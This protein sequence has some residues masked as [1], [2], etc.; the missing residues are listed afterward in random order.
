MNILTLTIIT[1]INQFIFIWLR[2]LNIKYVA[3]G[4]TL[5]AMLSGAGIHLA[6]LVSVAV[7]ATSTYEIMTEGKWELWPIPLASL[8]GGLYG[9]YIG[10]KKKK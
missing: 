2:T 1:L 3:D 10:M 6:W 5:A 7:G 8:I 4:K 9:T